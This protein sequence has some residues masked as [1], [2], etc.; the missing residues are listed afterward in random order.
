MVRSRHLLVAIGCV[1]VLRLEGSVPAVACEKMSES[2]EGGVTSAVEPVGVPATAFAGEELCLRFACGEKS[3]V[4]W[5][6]SAARRPFASGVI[7]AREGQA[8]IRFRTPDV[9]EGVVLP[10]QVAVKN[11][12]CKI[13]VFGKDPLEGRRQW[14]E[15]LQIVLFD[16][17][18]KTAKAFDEI[19]LPYRQVA[20]IG[21]LAAVSEGIVVVGE[22]L[23]LDEHRGLGGVLCQL[24]RKGVPVILL[25][26][27]SGRLTISDPAPERFELQGGDVGKKID[28]R[29]V[30]DLTRSHGYR[31]A[32]EENSP[33]LQITDRP[34]DYA[35]GDFRYDDARGRLCCLGWSLLDQWETS[36]APRFFLVHVL[37]IVSGGIDLSGGKKDD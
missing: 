27:E 35:W 32:G 24:A 26:P 1:A 25:V 6:A 19:A 11:A 12:V 10:I 37:E 15:Q 2:A 33:A 21:A 13:L 22:G 5:Q 18:Q 23:V 20:A 3:Q 28:S 7:V 36:P 14:A 16:P 30:A 9:K 34:S 31:I 4:A 29:T 17:P 8:E